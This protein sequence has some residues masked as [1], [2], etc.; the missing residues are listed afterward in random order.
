M[1]FD[2]STI[3]IKCWSLIKAVFPPIISLIHRLNNQHNRCHQINPIITVPEPVKL[4][5][6][7]RF[8]FYLYQNPYDRDYTNNYM[9]DKV[10]T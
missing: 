6:F 2:V 7:L 4:I 3:I 1:T 8:F 5:A 10:N 9:H